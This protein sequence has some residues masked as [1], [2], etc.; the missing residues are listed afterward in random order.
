L[1]IAVL[2]ATRNGART[3]PAVLAG[4]AALRPAPVPHRLI[5]VDNGSVDETPALLRAA[6]AARHPA[7]EVLHE[8][9][10][11][12]NRALN[13]ALPLALD[14]DLVVFTDDDAVPEPDWLAR[15]WEAAQ[16]RTGFGILGGGILP[17]WM[18]PPPAWIQDWGVPLDICYACTTAHREGPIEARLVWGANM[19][20]RG[21]LLREGHRLDAGIGP[22]GSAT[23][24]MGSEIEFTSRLGR[25]GHRAW[26]TPHAVVHHLVRPEQMTEAWVLQRAFRC[27]RGA[28][29]MRATGMTPLRAR[30]AQ[31]SPGL[32][33]RLAG[34]GAGAAV[35]RRALAPGRLR[36]RL[37]W[38]AALMRGKVAGLR[39]APERADAVPTDA[40]A[41]VVPMRTAATRPGD[42][43]AGA[44]G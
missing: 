28:S 36:F 20:V 38:Q 21:A 7:L 41:D 17:R 43:P 34:Y 16:A 18:E 4:H 30:L 42:A 32:L 35:A 37:E 23:Y 27:G 31:L 22:D 19:A 29:H 39:S 13:R 6:A 40:R 33:L 12:K 2:L 8:E 11:G 44:G 10:P 26:F 1:S 25:A 3:L 9:T 14:A 15:L 5:V 24:P